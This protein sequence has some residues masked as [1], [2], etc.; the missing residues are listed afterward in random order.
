MSEPA[1]KKNKDP[2]VWRRANRKYAASAHGKA[3]I[4][5]KSRIRS[6]VRNGTMKKPD[7]CPVCKRTGVRLIWH[8]TKGHDQDT[9]RWLCDKDHARLDPARSSS[10]LSK[11]VKRGLAEKKK[12]D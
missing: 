8:H 10:A 6:K 9:G 4:K 7:A 5:A 3:V 2:E 12:K 1:W 11:A